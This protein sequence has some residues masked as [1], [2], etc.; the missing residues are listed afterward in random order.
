MLQLFVLFAAAA[1]QGPGPGPGESP[2]LRDRAVGVTPAANIYI[3]PP[4]VPDCRTPEQEQEAL[5]QRAN[6][7]REVCE[8]RTKRVETRRR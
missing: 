1:A 4:K 8:P 7:E 5:A 2:I 6:G 3:L